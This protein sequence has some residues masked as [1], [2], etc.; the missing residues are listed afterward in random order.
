MR[1]S[2]TCF[3]NSAR[4]A[5]NTDFGSGRFGIAVAGL[6]SARDSVMGNDCLSLKQDAQVLIVLDVDR[7]PAKEALRAMPLWTMGAFPPPPH[8]R[9]KFGL[10]QHLLACLSLGE[11]TTTFWEELLRV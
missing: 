4:S 5:R 9:D 7:L 3:G 8:Q 1:T 10:Q 11:D 6:V 2:R